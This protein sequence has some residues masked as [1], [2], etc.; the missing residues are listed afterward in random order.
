MVMTEN[1]QQHVEDQ[2]SAEEREQLRSV[3]E[4]RRPLFEAL[5]IVEIADSS[6]ILDLWVELDEALEQGDTDSAQKI[7][8][9]CY[10]IALA[11]KKNKRSP[12]HT[13][14][15]RLNVVDMLQKTDQ[16]NKAH[17][18]LLG[19]QYFLESYPVNE[20]EEVQQKFYSMMAL[21]AKQSQ[22]DI[23]YKKYVDH[24]KKLLTVEEDF[25]DYRAVFTQLA[26]VGDLELF[27]EQ[28]HFAAESNQL[29]GVVY[30]LK[31]FLANGEVKVA[32]EVV[33]EIF[34]KYGSDFSDAHIEI[35]T[36]FVE[37]GYGDI[38]QEFF[39]RCPVKDSQQWVALLRLV[40]DEK[41]AFQLTDFIREIIEKNKDQELFVNSLF[42]RL[43]KNS[44]VE[45]AKQCM[46]LLRTEYA[47]RCFLRNFGYLLSQQDIKEVLS[48]FSTDI[49]LDEDIMYELSEEMVPEKFVSLMDSVGMPES[50][51]VENLTLS[52][53]SHLRNLTLAEFDRMSQDDDAITHSKEF[54][55]GVVQQLLAMPTV[56]SNAR[57]LQDL[58]VTANYGFD[59][60]NLQQ[61]LS[62]LSQEFDPNEY[63]AEE[64]PNVLHSCMLLVEHGYK[65][66]LEEV[67]SQVKV[68]IDS[69][70]TR[71]AGALI[72]LQR[73][74]RALDEPDIEEQVSGYYTELIADENTFQEQ[75]RSYLV[76][77][78]LKTG[79]P[80]SSFSVTLE[81]E[82]RPAVALTLE[83]LFKNGEV[84]RVVEIMRQT[85]ELF[86]FVHIL[87]AMASRGF[88]SEVLQFLPLLTETTIHQIAVFCINKP[89]KVDFALQLLDAISS[90][91]SHEYMYIFPETVRKNKEDFLKIYD[92]FISRG[93]PHYVL[94]ETVLHKIRIFNLDKESYLLP[95]I[96]RCVSDYKKNGP[97][98]Q[99]AL[100][101]DST[102][103]RYLVDAG[104]TE[105]AIEFR[106]CFLDP[107]HWSE[108]DSSA[109]YV[110][111]SAVKKV[112]Q[113]LNNIK[114]IPLDEVVPKPLSLYL[115]S[116]Q[117]ITEEVVEDLV[118]AG[119]SDYI[120]GEAISELSEDQ[121]PRA[122]QRFSRF[123]AKNVMES[124]G[125]VF[126]EETLHFIESL[127]ERFAKIY[128][129]VSTGSYREAPY[130]LENI[131]YMRKLE[132]DHPGI[133]S[134]LSSPKF[135]DISNFTRY[136]TSVLV[137]M[138]KLVTQITEAKRNGETLEP[139][140]YG[141]VLL[142]K[143]DW[144]GALHS[145][146]QLYESL[147]EQLAEQGYHPIIVEASSKQAALRRLVSVS[148]LFAQTISDPKLRPKIEFMMISA[149]GNTSLFELSEYNLIQKDDFTSIQPKVLAGLQALYA[150]EMPWLFHSCSTGA[151]NGIA[152]TVTHTFEG[153][154]SGPVVPTGLLDVQ[155]IFNADG[156]I[157]A[158]APQYS[159]SE[160][161]VY[162]N[163]ALVQ[164]YTQ[165]VREVWE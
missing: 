82:D 27:R 134:A 98:K 63:S 81:K 158:L 162:K 127:G 150:D 147:R 140:K 117:V 103:S 7:A 23:L 75:N 105:L 142:A 33:L 67:W 133:I 64:L 4:R 31:K 120:L 66:P 124:Y 16:H 12:E 84:D 135:F 76:S 69:L 26:E 19:M 112:N 56:T 132:R 153:M 57:K 108:L 36:S 77:Q 47:F 157:K 115:D 37:T 144:N 2:E 54:S 110:R 155:V 130:L 80:L 136:P 87:K 55:A 125:D 94:L 6:V 70:D 73:L 11:V 72:Q 22:L 32:E 138:Y 39:P 65:I 96:S 97:S 68:Q 45:M 146:P 44:T 34:S 30:G 159:E 152:Q 29:G 5:Q 118:S 141:V 92:Y 113:Y 53:A 154:V 143:A 38:A 60:T 52:Y 111:I 49:V 71:R 137:D 102:I 41:K 107:I 164:K 149:H 106:N 14:N 40:S 25:R 163:T 78:T 122:F 131:N 145:S 1:E 62:H 91:H 161:H 165:L 21:R 114:D 148:K 89:G 126:D 100:L 88:E 156:S 28:I 59:K 109:E 74:A 42:I 85:S 35:I 90:V 10:Q 8:D 61:V 93:T 160:T 46:A 50:D 24:L 48:L 15:V 17:A 79:D 83:E 99:F 58:A 20:N 119:A 86:T 129:D 18:A 3:A 128:F 101:F 123:S 95:I 13:L 43:H 9:T 139:I 51:K 151:P 121:Q 104:H 116:I